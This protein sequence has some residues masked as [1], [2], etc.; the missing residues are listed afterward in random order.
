[1]KRISLRQ[2]FLVA[3]CF[4]AVVLG[5]I[6]AAALDH[7]AGATSTFVV[8]R[9]L[10]TN[11]VETAYFREGRP[12]LI[13]KGRPDAWITLAEWKD[14][15]GTS[16]FGAAVIPDEASTGAAAAPTCPLLRPRECLVQFLP[17]LGYRLAR[18]GVLS[19]RHE[20]IRAG[21]NLDRALTNLTLA[22]SS[23]STQATWTAV[24]AA[25]HDP[26]NSGGLYDSGCVTYHGDVHW[27]ACYGRRT[28]NDSDQS[29]DY[30]AEETTGQ[31]YGIYHNPHQYQVLL[32]GAQQ[33]LYGR[34][35]VWSWAPN[36]TVGG[37]RPCGSVTWSASYMGTGVSAS[38]P[39]C[40]DFIRGY[41]TDAENA[42][43]TEWH[44]AVHDHEC[45][46]AHDWTGTA[47]VASARYG[48]GQSSGFSFSIYGAYCYAGEGGCH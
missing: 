39:K 30:T 24:A 10:G 21:M 1:M 13:Y 5:L 45:C 28:V 33:L 36:G 19:L 17:N 43:N 9:R 15:S 47:G 2:P 4:A 6:P 41:R 11:T 38:S 18:P 25:S 27:G 20:S 31:G 44:G 32:Q 34:G 22:R 29:R 7:D 23:S 16:R 14:S 35:Q 42:F 12:V 46:G 3:A 37:S 40:A 8:S 26:Q 48:Q